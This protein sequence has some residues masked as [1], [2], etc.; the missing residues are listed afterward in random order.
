MHLHRVGGGAYASCGN[1]TINGGTVTATAN[2]YYYN[3]YNYVGAGIGSGYAT[4]NLTSSCGN[5]TITGGT[6]VASSSD[7]A[8]AIGSGNLESG[9]LATCGNITIVDT[10]TRVTATKGSNATNSIGAG[11]GGSCGTVTIGATWDSENET[12]TGGTEGEI[13]TSPY[14]YPEE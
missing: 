4:E 3:S 5:I 2:L 6:V 7:Y 1:I 10:V 8:A 14:T 9:K 11:T 13:T 12:Y